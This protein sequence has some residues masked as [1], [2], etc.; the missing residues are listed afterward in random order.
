LK[1]DDDVPEDWDDDDF[2]LYGDEDEDD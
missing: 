1:S 2:D